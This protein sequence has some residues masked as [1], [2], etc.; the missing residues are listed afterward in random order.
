MSGVDQCPTTHGPKAK[1]LKPGA[2]ELARLARSLPSV[3]GMPVW[4]SVDEMADSPEFRT[5]LEQEFPHGA[6]EMHRAFERGGESRRDFLKLMG[7][8]MALAGVAVMPGCRRPEGKIL[9]YSRNVPE[10]IIPG[11][12]LFYATSFPRPGGGADG[13]VVETHEGRPTKIEGNPLHPMNR[14]RVGIW[15]LASILSLYDVDRV[16]TPMYRN[17]SKGRVEATWDDFRAW[18]GEN[19][20]KLAGTDGEALAFIVDKKSSPTRDALKGEVLKRYPKATWI[21]YEPTGTDAA[22]EGAR[23]ALGS[24]MR[25]VLNFSMDTARVVVSL[26]RDFLSGG[27]D[28]IANARGFA[29]TRRVMGT[30]DAMSRLYVVESGFTVTGGQADH[31]LGLAPSQITAFA[32][33]LARSVA[34]LLKGPGA[35]ALLAGLGAAQSAKM[36]LEAQHAFMEG[37]ARDLVDAAN[38]GRSIIVAGPSQPAQVHAVVAALNHLLGNIGQ[39]VSYLP[40]DEDDGP[41]SAAR[42]AALTKAMKAGAIGAVVCIDANPVYAAGG[43]LEFAEAYKKVAGTI[44][45]GV[46]SS[47]TAGES[48]WSLNGTHYLESWGDVRAHDGTISPV[49][50]MIAPLYEPAMSELEFLALVAGGDFKAKPDGYEIVRAAWKAGAQGDFERAWRRALHDGVMA[51]S[52]AKPQTPEVNL[53]AVGEAAGKVAAGK[54]PSSDAL[55]VVF[56]LGRVHDGRYANCAW[57]QEL[58]QIGTMVVWDNPVLLSPKTAQALGVLPKAYTDRDPS[59]MYTKEKYP[60]GRMVEMSLGGRTI[61][62]PAWILPGMADNTAILTFGYGRRSAG[63]VGDGVG[64]DVYPLWASG[65]SSTSAAGATIKALDEFVQVTSTQNNWSMEGRTGIVRAVDLPAWQKFGDEKGRGGRSLYKDSDELTFGERLGEL[66]H[67]PPNESIYANPYNDSRRDAAAGSI[68]AKGPQWG[69]TIDL[70]TCTGCGACTVACQSE[71]NIPVVGKKET[72]K[73][74]EMTWI[75]VDRYFVGDDF[76]SP[77]HM[78]HQPV[79]CVHCENAPCEVVCPVNATVHG[80]EGINY[81]VYNRCIGTRYCAN[82]CP[83][84]VRRYNFFEYGKLEFNGDYIGKE[85]LESIAPER[86]GVNGSNVHNKVNINLIPPRLRQKITEIERMGKNPNVSVRMRGI[87]EKCTYCVQRINAAR[88]ECKLNEVKGADGKLSIPDGFFQVACQQACPSEAIVF[89]DMLDASSKVAGTLGNPRS[90]KLLNFLNTRPRTSHMVRIMNPNPSL[91]S[92]E[93]KGHWDSPFGHHGPHEPGGHEEGTPHQGA[94]GG[95]GH[96]FRF[97]R[98]RRSDDDGYRLSL[99]VLGERNG[100][101]A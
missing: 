34:N 101:R 53:G 31:R 79:A 70:S 49:Q 5:H 83:Y 67:A 6:L 17:P 57:L 92:P 46:S 14:G 47:E 30:K 91:C 43:D 18:A 19:F 94:P 21:A 10:E 56:T 69:M 35:E 82:N 28:E 54:L 44:C 15:P 90:Y 38:R 65:A 32:L 61:K 20:A 98:T 41:G 93:R 33:E 75:R 25:E 52:A 58:P 51:S 97:E 100:E 86:G 45:L 12:P 73:G 2:G 74:R 24:P 60:S 81:M 68:Y 95:E 42:L 37:C 50:P 99:S 1:Q 66:G 13:L 26:D 80:P 59:T 8:S 62:L 55:D 72:A 16:K 27:A 11:K 4:R 88:V 48:L 85:A 84:K 3:R 36:G 23:I 7:A 77:E 9:P 39:G 78:L 63:L 40:M 64:F 71:N 96:A 76:N 89:G 87:M 29:A 22:A